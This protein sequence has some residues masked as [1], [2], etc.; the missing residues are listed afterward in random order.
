MIIK[1]NIKF[2]MGD[3]NKEKEQEIINEMWSNIGRTFAEYVFLK[4]FRYNKIKPT[5]IN[6]NGTQYFDQ[7]YSM[8]LL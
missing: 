8:I 7:I 5:H 3:I 2:A 1:K 6:I 4:D